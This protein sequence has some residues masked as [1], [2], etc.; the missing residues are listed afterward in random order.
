MLKMADIL[1]EMKEYEKASLAYIKVVRITEANGLSKWSINDH[2][3]KYL[4][5][6][7]ASGTFTPLQL[8]NVFLVFLI[9]ISVNRR[10][11]SRVFHV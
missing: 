3:Y 8:G 7:L 4:L 1:V 2:L 9:L 11:Y 10:M 5:C 6:T